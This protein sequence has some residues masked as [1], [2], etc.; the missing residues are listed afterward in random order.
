MMGF[1]SE[2]ESVGETEFTRVHAKEL[3]KQRVNVVSATC[4]EQTSQKKRSST[5]SL[6]E[7]SSGLHVLEWMEVS[8]RNALSWW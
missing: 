5:N 8:P 1:V 4:S 3:L 6:A 2:G 7:G